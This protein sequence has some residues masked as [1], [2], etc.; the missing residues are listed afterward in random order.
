MY[1][2]HNNSVVKS[3]FKND[4]KSYSLY[5]LKFL[6]MYKEMGNSVLSWSTP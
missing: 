6:C 3:V 4:I 1:K 2:Y 5:Y